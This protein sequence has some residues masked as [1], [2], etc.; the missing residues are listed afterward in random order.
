MASYKVPVLMEEGWCVEEAWKGIMIREKRRSNLEN[1]YFIEERVDSTGVKDKDVQ[2]GIILSTSIALAGLTEDDLK[3]FLLMA[4]LSSGKISNDGKV[5]Q[6][7]SSEWEAEAIKK[8]IKNADMGSSISILTDLS[9]RDPYLQP[10]KEILVNNEDDKIKTQAS[11][12]DSTT[13]VVIGKDKRKLILKLIKERDKSDSEKPELIITTSSFENWLMPKRQR[14]KDVYYTYPKLSSEAEIFMREFK[15]EY[16]YKPS[17]CALLGYDAADIAIKSIVEGGP[18]YEGIKHYLTHNI[19]ELI[20]VG[21]MGFSE[22]GLPYLIGKK[23]E[24]VFGIKYVDK[25]GNFKSLEE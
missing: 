10:L 12:V 18:S 24:D 13:C 9:D 25:D 17:V 16:G 14:F 2:L 21:K 23:G 5:F 1:V 8:Y 20:T 15:K 19:F 7:L 3:D 4:P 6:L 22:E 11:E